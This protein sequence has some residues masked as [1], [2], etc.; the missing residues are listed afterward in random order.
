M[1]VFEDLIY[2]DDRGMQE[3]LKAVPNDKLTMA[4]KTAPEDIKEKIF[5]NMSKRASDML[6]E[7][8]ETMGPVKVSEVD[9]AQQE[10]VNIAKKL[11]GEGK[12]F[13]AR[14]GEGDALV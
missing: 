2:I 11:E 14:G 9:S 1:F 4:M 6:R 10:I 13:V 5:R 8:L 12:L 3:L 7:D